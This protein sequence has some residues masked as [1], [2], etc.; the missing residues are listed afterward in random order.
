LATAKNPRYL[1]HGAFYADL[2]RQVDLYFARTG[3]VPNGGPGMY[4]KTA[5]MFGWFAGSY[6]LLMFWATTGWQA[7]AL[8]I[9]LGMAMAGSA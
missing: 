7:C 2:K 3:G 4:L 9:S 5:V 6:A 8:A 1:P